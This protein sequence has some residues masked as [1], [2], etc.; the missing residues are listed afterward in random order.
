MNSKLLTLNKDDL[1]LLFKSLEF[2][3]T[4][5]CHSDDFMIQSFEEIT[6]AIAKA[7]F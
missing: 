6:L 3:S 7:S 2:L 4:M 5:I 1:A